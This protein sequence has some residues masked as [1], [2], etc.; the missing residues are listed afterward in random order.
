MVTDLVIMGVAPV[1][2]G[3]ALRLHGERAAQLEEIEDLKL[4]LHTRVR[5]VI[6]AYE[7]GP[8]PRDSE[9]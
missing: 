7:H 8:A 2:V 6:H 1:A 4:R 5:A 3:H 9:I